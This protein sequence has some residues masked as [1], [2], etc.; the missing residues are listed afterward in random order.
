MIFR[1]IEEKTKKNR[2]GKYGSREG[3]RYMIIK[4]ED[5]FI[6]LDKVKW[7][8]VV[9]IGVVKSLF[10]LRI[11]FSPSGFLELD[12]KYGSR[13]EIYNVIRKAEVINF[14]TESL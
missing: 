14:S 10:T 13:E 5:T 11:E 6:N 7:M 3:F 8:Q 12:R 2:R 9:S 4:I 1:C